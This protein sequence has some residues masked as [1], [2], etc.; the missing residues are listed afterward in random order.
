MVRHSFCSRYT[1]TAPTV[2]R[3]VVGKWRTA[4]EKPGEEVVVA[5]RDAMTIDVHC[6]GGA[7]A[8]ESIVTALVLLGCELVP[9]QQLD[10]DL[11]DDLVQREALV[12][13]SQAAT[14]TTA[15]H[16]LCQYQGALAIAIGQLIDQLASDESVDG[17]ARRQ[18]ESLLAT[19]DFGRHTVQ[20]YRVAVCGPPNVGK[21]S[22]INALVGFERSIVFDEPGTT[23]DVLA[24]DTA[25]R[26]WPVRLFDTAGLR[27]TDEPIE[28]EGIERAIHEAANADLVLLVTALDEPWDA[29]IEPW[30]QRFPTA[31]L[32]HN[33]SD[34]KRAGERPDGLTISVLQEIGLDLLLESIGDTLLANVPSR[35]AALLFNERQKKLALDALLALNGGRISDCRDLLAAVLNRASYN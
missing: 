10:D 4:D 19:F 33:K 26:G 32:V 29:A 34:V 2:G 25:I 20:P 18:L 22:L 8:V 11:A 23:R 3:I 9:W 24:V 13:L 21:S 16:L 12:A 5:R 17:R 28:A 35:G 1:E 6:H 7:A 14:E 27:V 31:L 15:S 30:S